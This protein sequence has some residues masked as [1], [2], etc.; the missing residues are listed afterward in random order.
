MGDDAVSAA[1]AAHTGAPASYP[2]WGANIEAFRRRTADEWLQQLW[3][4]DIPA[5]EATTVGGILSDTQAHANDYAIEIDD[6]NGQQSPGGDGSPMEGGVATRWLELDDA[7]AACVRG[8]LEDAKTELT[9]RR[10]RE[11]LG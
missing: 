6:P 4:N 8:E 2:N 5:Q 7:I 9:L 3:D 1:N 11:H 10:L